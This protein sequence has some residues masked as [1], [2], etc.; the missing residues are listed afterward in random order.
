MCLPVEHGRSL[1]SAVASLQT[2]RQIADRVRCVKRIVQLCAGISVIT[3]DE[4]PMIL[5]LPV[6]A[7]S[8]D[9]QPSAYVQMQGMFWWDQFRNFEAEVSTL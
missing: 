7:C 1:F 3:I 4:Y 2:Q 8:N 6:R 5:L 9:A